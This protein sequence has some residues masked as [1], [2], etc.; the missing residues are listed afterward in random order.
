MGVNTEYFTTVHCGL[1]NYLQMAND[2][3]FVKTTIFFFILTQKNINLSIF[4]H[5]LAP[6]LNLGYYYQKRKTQK[7]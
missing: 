2:T 5:I 1:N 6:I 7:G 4:C 3:F